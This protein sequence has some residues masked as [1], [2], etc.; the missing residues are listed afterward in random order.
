MR[1]RPRS[2]CASTPTRRR[3]PG[4]VQVVLGVGLLAIAIVALAILLQRAPRRA[5]TNLTQD[6]GFVI[7][8]AAGQELCEPAE[9]LPGDTG[10]LGLD[11]SAGARPGPALAVVISGPRGT[12]SSGRLAAGWRSGAIRIPV[13]RVRD[14]V[15][16]ATV[17]VHNLGA[18]Q[19]A[20]GGAA[21]D[22]SFYIDLAGKPLLG[23]MRIEYMRPGSETWLQFTPALA[24]RF[25]LGKSDA[26]RHWELAA[27]L[28][29]M[30]MALGLAARAIVK[31]RPS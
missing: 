2:A 14:T 21:P 10:A 29:L 25:A 7:P 20:F 16:G 1:L 28:I 13:R 11:A 4:L 19:V 31:E 17:C 22:A 15:P 6:V 18:S 3:R 23:R 5:G 24:Q 12:V 26:L 30:A 8:L 27:I 9:L